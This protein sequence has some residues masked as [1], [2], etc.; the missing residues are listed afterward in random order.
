MDKEARAYQ[1]LIKGIQQ[2]VRDTVDKYSDKTYTGLITAYDSDEDEYTVNLNGVEYE[3]VST[4]GG[5][6]NIYET[7]HVLVPQGNFSNMFILK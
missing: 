4:I 5:S 2:F 6:C 3:H 1:S 7:V